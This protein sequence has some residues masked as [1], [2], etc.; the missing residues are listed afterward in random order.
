[1]FRTSYKVL[2]GLAVAATIGGI[3]TLIPAPNASYPNILGYK[4]LC[5]FAPAGTFFCFFI[6]GSACF[7][8]STYIKDTVGDRRDR[9]RR[10]AKR[11]IPV[12]FVFVLGLGSLG[13][14]LSVKAPYLDAES[15]ASPSYTEGEN[16]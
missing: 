1:M 16:Q 2:L 12:A 8:R 10:H 11:L 15:T 9:F 6:A 7:I 5:T 13:W 14:Y 4:S 3:L